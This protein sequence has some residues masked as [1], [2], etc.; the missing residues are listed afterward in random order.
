MVASYDGGYIFTTGG[1]DLSVNMWTINHSVLDQSIDRNGSDI[2]SFIDL[3]EGGKGGKFWN[4]IKEYFYYAQIK[5]YKEIGQSYQFDLLDLSRGEYSND[6]HQ[7][8]NTV[9]L[10]LLI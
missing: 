10:L 7:I 1:S 6:F 4:E 8:I 2:Q 3:I 9:S 5:R